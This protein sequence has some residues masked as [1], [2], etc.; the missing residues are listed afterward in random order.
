MRVISQLQASIFAIV[1]GVAT[2][3]PGVLRAAPATFLDAGAWLSAI[4]GL[5][6]PGQAQLP[7]VARLVPFPE[8][9]LSNMTFSDAFGSWTHD[10][11]TAAYVDSDGMPTT[12]PRSPLYLYE[13]LH[14]WLSDPF[15]AAGSE[16]GGF[17]VQFGCYTAVFPCLGLQVI[18]I[19]LGR[20]ILGFGGHL[21]Y[22]KGYEN[23]PGPVPIPLLADAH[24]SWPTVPPGAEP[25]TIFYNGF[26]GVIFDQP[27]SVIRIAWREGENADDSSSVRFTDSFIIRVVPEPA[28]M[29]MLAV[30]LL[31]LLL[32]SRPYCAA[33]PIASRKA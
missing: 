2:A 29:A 6:G 26:F 23:F 19:D 18:E 9:P 5:P 8:V 1:F 4:A 22:Y 11:Q 17:S 3:T 15:R 31:G 28:S 25:E 20:E 27:T 24:A 33:A 16:A 13:H 7:A 12:G 21:D 32:A 30:A 10:N 14:Y